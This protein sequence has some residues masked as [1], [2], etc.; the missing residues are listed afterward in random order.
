[1]DICGFSLIGGEIMRNGIVSFK[2]TDPKTGK[3]MEPDFFH[4]TG[5]EI[6]I[7]LQKAQEAFRY[8]S[9]FT[10]QKRAELLRRICE[11]ILEIGDSLIDRCCSETGLPSSRIMGERARTLAQLNMFS[12]LIDE[13][14]WIDARIDT[15]E[16]DR[17]PLPKPDVRRML[18]PIGPVVVFG[19]SNFPLAFSVAGGDTASALASG[20]PVIVKAHR[21]HPGTAELIGN[22]INRAITALDL[23]SGLFS[24]VHGTGATT[25][26]AL[27]KHPFTKAVGFTG[28]H[29]GGR[30]LFDIASTRTE[31]IP[32][33][34][35][36]GSI[37]PI[38]IL[39]EAMQTK[40][41]SLAE[42]I[43]QSVTLG[44]GQFCT[45][46]GLIVGLDSPELNKLLNLLKNHFEK[47]TPDTMLNSNIRESYE[48]NSWKLEEQPNVDLTGKSLV[49]ADK[50]RNEATA[51]LFLTD[52]E[53]FLKNN[54]VS[55]EIFGPATVVVKSKSLK[56][57][58]NIASNLE[59][60]LTATI[61]GTEKDLTDFSELLPILKNKVG[62]MI[63]NGYPT[64]VEVCPSMNHGGPY[65]ATTDVHY[66][67][68]GT[69][70]IY[71]FV[72][73]ISYQNF[74][75][76]SLPDVLQNHNPLKIL[77]LVNGNYTTEAISINVV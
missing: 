69:A 34:A 39:P 31:P 11:E 7:A 23:P 17:Q 24:L 64:G 75:D 62:R 63:F 12:E 65:P 22:A 8:S 13:G 25:G 57:M 46:P 54:I 74:P 4:A 51:K 10:S 61:H 28:S 36:M 9:S 68:V 56:D 66:T 14:S 21:S 20:C 47:T 35:E 60:H 44:T 43:Q 73:P 29:S 6:D 58:I 77:R 2:A 37:N 15:A 52:S 40:P 19:A 26:S 38:F 70:A 30:A 55:E 45:N 5:A 76:K 72:R 71:R 50:N 18:Q 53:T 27:V 42:G 33:Y 59:G 49:D 41:A 32:V 16:P 67:S 48:R 3:T 1:M